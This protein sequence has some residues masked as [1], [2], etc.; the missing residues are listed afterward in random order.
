ML[1]ICYVEH[2]DDAVK[3]SILRERDQLESQERL[4]HKEGLTGGFMILLML[5]CFYHLQVS[6]FGN[7]NKI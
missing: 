6:C 3:I 7:Y 1:G 5:A 4:D 2:M